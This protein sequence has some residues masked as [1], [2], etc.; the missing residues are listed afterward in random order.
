MGSVVQSIWDSV[1]GRTRDEPEIMEQANQFVRWASCPYHKKFMAW[2][3]EEADG[4]VPIA[5]KQVDL[6]IG[7][8]R[9]NT[10]KEIRRYLQDQEARA[11]AAL[12]RENHA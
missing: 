2:L 5:G 8:A 12:D 11:S 4:P 7:T 1:A 10:F 9:A 6:I 3:Y